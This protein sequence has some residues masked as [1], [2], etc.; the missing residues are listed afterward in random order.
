MNDLVYIVGKGSIWNN[1]E[2]KYSLRS[3][4]M[5]VQNYN[6]LVIVGHAPNFVDKQKIIHIPAEDTHANKAVNIMRKVKLAC[7]N[8]ELSENIMLM[9]D[10]YFVVKNISADS[11][12]YTWKN[13]LEEALKRNPTY[14]QYY[15]H[16]NETF[17]LL[18]NENKTAFNYDMHCPII[19]NR[20]KLLEVVNAYEWDNLRFGY[21]L[22]SLYCNTLGV[23]GEFKPDV[24][25]NHTRRLKDMLNIISQTDCFSIGDRAINNQLGK[26]LNLLYPN[27]SKYEL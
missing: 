8:K 6:R 12:P 22:R 9:N 15:N 17:K 19:Y 2:L 11:Y 7:E 27:Y 20:Q 26:L 4:E 13:T 21:I 5:F 23:E 16:I 14:S 25:L 3:A 1:Q 24:K 18:K 10:D